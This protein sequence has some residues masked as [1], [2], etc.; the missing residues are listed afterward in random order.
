VTYSNLLAT[1][2]LPFAVDARALGVKGCSLV[3]ALARV[4]TRLLLI[5]GTSVLAIQISEVLHR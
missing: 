3:A 5:F 2:V 4:A 1:A